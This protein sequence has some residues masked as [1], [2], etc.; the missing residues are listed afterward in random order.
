MD[1]L[2]VHSTP[3]WG[4]GDGVRCS[5]TAGG[6]MNGMVVWALIAVWSSLLVVVAVVAVVRFVVVRTHHW[7]AVCCSW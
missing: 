6:V 4:S 3:W 7:L 5:C 2:V 1:G